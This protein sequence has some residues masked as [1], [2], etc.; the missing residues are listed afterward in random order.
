MA[1]I[2]VRIPLMICM[3]MLATASVFAQ[4]KIDSL[5]SAIKSSSDESSKARSLIALSYEYQYVNHNKSRTTAEEALK[6]ATK[7]NLNKEIF[8]A[9]GQ[10]ALL[11]SLSGDYNTALKYDNSNLDHVL[12]QKDSSQIAAVLNYIGNDY[13]DLE[14]YD[15]AYYY[16]TQSHKVASAIHDSL[17]MVKSLHNVGTV[18]SELGQYDIALQHFDF[19]RQIG[20]KIKDVDGLAYMYDEKAEVYLKTKEYDKARAALASAAK[21]IR[22]RNLSVIEHRVMIGAAKLELALGEYDEAL[23]YYDSAYELHRKHDNEFGVAETNLGKSGVYLAQGKYK[24]A[25]ALLIQTSAAAH[26]LNATR[27]ETDSYRL[28]SELAEKRGDF[29]NALRYYKNHKMLEDSVFSQEMMQKLYQSQLRFATEGKDSEIAS[30]TKTKNEQE[31]ILKRRQ[32]LFNVM[33][34]VLALCAVLLFSIYRSGQ[35]R[36][37]INKLL[38]EHQAEIKKRSVELEQLNQVKDKFF[39]IISH[40]LRSPMN[41][42]AGILDLA[43]KKHLDPKEFVQ[44]TKELRVQFNHT[45]TLINNLLDWTLL[46]MDK[47]NIHEDRVELHAMVEE[48]FKLFSALQVKNTQMQ[49]LIKPGTCA[50]ADTNMVNLVFRNLILN[51]IKFTEVGGIVTVAAKEKAGFVEVS[52]SDNGV[53][54]SPDVQKI[55]FEKTT[56]Y[57]T[58]G[59]ANE[60]GTGLG[61]ILCKEFVERNG[62]SI[63]LESEVGKGSTFFFTLKKA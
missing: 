34:V 29:K 23:A 18:F 28:L 7:N 27:L 57:S 47:L 56:G 60:K 46:Q 4:L 50:K 58:R 54:I 11:A 38:M 16:F 24:E 6:V 63:W 15:E 41:A 61:L 3:L 53:G 31:D 13:H 2:T 51:A 32:F 26:Q 25:E 40:D 48:N 49:N 39:S 45:K 17:R 1:F 12:K 21:V 14:R 9:Y 62:G 52:I 44:L 33:I 5:E 59:T 36:I 8:E 20:E 43:E 10:L 22:D 37:R 35:R 30:L 19:A 42:L 55:L